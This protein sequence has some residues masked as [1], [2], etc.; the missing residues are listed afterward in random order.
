MRRFARFALLVAAASAALALAGP[1][2]LMPFKDA[3]GAATEVSV[4]FV[5]DF[6]GANKVQ[7]TCVKVP[8]TDDEYQA[9]AAF[10]QQ[11]NEETPTYNDSGLLCSIGG[12]PNSGCG[13]SDGSGFI[14]W[15]YWHGDTGGWEYSNTGASG[16]VHTCNV[17][18]QECDVEGWRF[19]DPGS[20]NPND[21]PPEA[22]AD[23]ADICPTTPPPT[24]TTSAS[25]PT[26]PGTATP[27]NT[28]PKA[29][30]VSPSSGGGSN[31]SVTGSTQTTGVSSSTQPVSHGG[32]SPTTPATAKH[33]GSLPD[34]SA[35]AT[36]A[37]E[38]NVNIQ[39]LGGTPARG[40]HGS[41][42]G[43]DSVWITGGILLVLIAGS[44]YGW[45]RRVRSP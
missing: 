29:T 7:V 32:S 13:Q 11:E 41:S 21:P 35:T 31:P 30:T 45:R 23:Y 1:Y 34:T 17:Q 26:T 24:T 28:I 27:S 9:L 3:A 40:N 39:A 4:A 14:Y 44:V 15:S 12:I 33:S 6:G 36:T 25:P 2:A 19:E 10:T 20:G 42:G 16:T 8:S 38:P 37:S 5:V 22:I 43:A 18:G